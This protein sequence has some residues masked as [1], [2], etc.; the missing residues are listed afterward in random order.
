MERSNT[1]HAGGTAWLQLLG[2]CPWC[3][4]MVSQ[5]QSWIAANGVV[6]RRICTQKSKGGRPVRPHNCPLGQNQRCMMGLGENAVPSFC[7]GPG[8]AYIGHW[9]TRDTRDTSQN[10]VPGLLHCKLT[11]T[12]PRL[13]VLGG[14][15]RSLKLNPP[16][17]STRRGDDYVDCVHAP[18]PQQ[19]VCESHTLAV[20]ERAR[21]LRAS[22]LHKHDR[23]GTQTKVELR[24][25]EACQLP[26]T[27]TR[28]VNTCS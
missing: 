9:Y 19:A 12:S 3:P 5:P 10:A 24:N 28:S 20:G 27:N 7:L 11:P 25:F 23:R 17:Q 26:S 6:P 4:T 22:L 2:W 14:Q 21:E 1:I 16:P 8:K 18:L 15:E 13:R